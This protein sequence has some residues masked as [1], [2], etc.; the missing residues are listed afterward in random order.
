MK[1]AIKKIKYPVYYLDFE[2]YNCPL[3]RFKGDHPYTQ[4][5]FQYS[6]HVEKA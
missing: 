4:S 6:L 3:P 5:L 2:S 1:E